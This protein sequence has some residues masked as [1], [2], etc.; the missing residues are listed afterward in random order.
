MISNLDQA[1]DYQKLPMITNTKLC[2]A[3]F[4]PIQL[5]ARKCPHCHQIQSKAAAMQN[6]PAVSWIIV[7][8][9]A[10]MVAGFCL[11]IYGIF[12]KNE[13]R[14]PELNVGPATVRI[15][16]NQKSPRAS[17]FAPITNEDIIVWTDPSIQAQFFDNAGREI[18]VHY[19][20]HHFNLFPK[21]S[22]EA[23][24]SGPLN[25]APEDYAKCKLSVLNVK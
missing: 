8:I 4:E 11:A 3:C 1:P 7:A 17:C 24:V 18:D 13:Q 15:S 23:R 12:A 2:L 21:F 6:H 25:A 9:I 20:T 14:M 19:E 16:N 22:V 10:A 5:A